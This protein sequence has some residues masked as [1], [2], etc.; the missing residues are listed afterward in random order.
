MKKILL[1]VFLVLCACSP[2]PEKENETVQKGAGFFLP[3]EGETFVVATDSITNI[4]KDY[5]K[6]HN[7]RDLEAIM[8]MN[9]DSIKIEGPDGR[10]IKGKEMHKAALS[11][12]FAAEDPKW[13][14]YW[15]MPYKAVNGGE[16][17]IIAGHEVKMMVDGKE[18]TKLQMI[19]GEIVNG[20]V[21]RFYVYSKDIASKKKEEEAEVT[22]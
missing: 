16:E 12:W 7:E 15:A 2:A 4:W 5:I 21:K 6:A 13:T 3:I 9:S 22:E 19:D 11:A 14:I 8:A 10:V 1:L 17:W 20:K 18:M